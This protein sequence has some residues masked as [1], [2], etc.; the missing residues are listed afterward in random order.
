MKKFFAA[1]TNFPSYNIPIVHAAFSVYYTALWRLVYYTFHAA[2]SP[3]II[4]LCILYDFPYIIRRSSSVW[5]I[6]P[7]VYYTDF[8]SGCFRLVY[9]THLPRCKFLL[10]P[11]IIPSF[12]RRIIYQTSKRN[13][14]N[15]FPRPYNLISFPNH[16]TESVP[17][18]T[19]PNQRR[20]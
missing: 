2:F 11:Y 9:Y 17:R 3:Y 13:R 5:Y 10:P 16:R 4:R 18:N 15:F 14:G 7:V 20:L 8:P 19:P 6:I 1:K 12:F